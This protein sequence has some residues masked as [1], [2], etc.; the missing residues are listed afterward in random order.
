MGGWVIS[1]VIAI[2]VTGALEHRRLHLRDYVPVA[3]ALTTTALG[4]L[5][6]ILRAN[7]MLA[8]RFGPVRAI[9]RRGRGTVPDPD[10]RGVPHRARQP[11]RA[12]LGGPG[13]HTGARPGH[14]APRGQQPHSCRRIIREGQDA[15]GQT[16]LRWSAVLLFALLALAAKF[17]LDIVLGAALAGSV[18][19]V[20]SPSS[21]R[22]SGCELRFRQLRPLSGSLTRS[23]GVTLTAWSALMSP[24]HRLQVLQELPVTS[25]EA[26]R[27]AS[28][29]VRHRVPGTMSS[30]RAT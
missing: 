20:T 26:N 12:S 10:H 18:R 15:T 14:P 8:G 3:L 24:D 13:G 23:T 19:T 28:K 17:G 5:L 21:A 4:T 16:M 6:P 1:A 25:R 27:N 2:G 9:G 7:D 30:T 11:G 22:I 29:R